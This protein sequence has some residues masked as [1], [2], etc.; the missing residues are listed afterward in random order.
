VTGLHPQAPALRIGHL[1]GPPAAY[2]ASHQ[3]ESGLLSRLLVAIAL[4]VVAFEVVTGIRSGRRPT[5]RSGRSRAKFFGWYAAGGRSELGRGLILAALL[6]VDAAFRR[7]L[8]L[9]DG[10]VDDLQDL[11]GTKRGAQTAEGR[12]LVGSTC[13]TRP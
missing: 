13:G 2:A 9:V 7:G 5:S 10:V 4:A 11:D 8:V 12:E 1:P 6:L 3:R